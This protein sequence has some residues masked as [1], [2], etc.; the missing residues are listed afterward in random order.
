MRALV[1]SGGGVKGSYQLGVLKKWLLDDQVEY[2][3]FSGVSVGALN[4]A[5]LAQVPY[6][7]P[8]AAYHKL[9]KIWNEVDNSNIRKDWGF[10][11]KLAAL[12]KGHVYNSEP[13]KDWVR[14]DVDEAALLTSGK[15]LLVGATSLDTGEYRVAREYTPDIWKWVYSSAAFPLFFEE[16]QIENN[17][18]VDGGVRN[19]TPLGEVIRLGVSEIDVV[20]ASNPYVVKSWDHKGKAIWEKAFR[21]LDILMTEITLTDLQVV[22]LKNDLARLGADIQP[23]KVRLIYPPGELVD[24]ALDFNPEAIKKMQDLG[25]Q[26]ACEAEEIDLKTLFPS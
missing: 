19:V 8:Q 11:G 14:R 20:L 15:R 22:G 2:D 9:S 6:G 13:L 1:L 18:W 17:L 25:Y 26:Q 10:F 4:S 12:W 7:D 5:V 3:V 24:D 21:V 16:G 23:I